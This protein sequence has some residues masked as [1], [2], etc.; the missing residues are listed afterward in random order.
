M[1]PWKAL[2]IFGLLTFT[3]AAPAQTVQKK[4]PAR[5]APNPAYARVEDVPGLPRVLILGDSISIGYTVPLRKELEGQANVHRPAANCGPSSRGVEALD[6]WLGTGKWDVIHFNHGLHDLKFVD[7]QGKNAAPEKGHRQVPLDQYEKNL[8]TIVARLKKTGARLIF[9]TTTPVPPGEPQRKVGDDQAYNA[10]AWKVMK[11]QGVAVD[12]LYAAVAP[13]FDRYAIRP[14]N[15]HFNPEG[16]A[17]LARQA[18]ASIRQALPN[19]PQR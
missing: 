7:E 9:A 2:T 18:A 11:E 6:S 19:Q 13:E 5:R 1:P 16:Y 8:N 3:V 14:G 4:A 17:L 10:I 15:V 12:D